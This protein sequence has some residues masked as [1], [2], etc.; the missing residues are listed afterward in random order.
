MVLVFIIIILIIFNKIIMYFKDTINDDQYDYCN[1]LRNDH[2]IRQ[3][4]D[5]KSGVYMFKNNINGKCYIG[6]SV[7]LN[8]R[9][10]AHMHLIDKSNLPLYRAIKN[11]GLNNFSFINLEYCEP[12]IIICVKLEQKYIDFYKP[13]YNILK[14]AKSSMGFKHSKGTIANLK[15]IHKGK[16][17]PRFGTTLQTNKKN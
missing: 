3:N 15:S 8:R 16:L 6:S 2:E 7:N 11:Y 9:F 10:R 5:K 4:I 13:D 17:H 1:S 12:N 14:I